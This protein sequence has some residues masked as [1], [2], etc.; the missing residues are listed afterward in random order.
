MTQGLLTLAG[1]DH[2]PGGKTRIRVGL[3]IESE[4][5]FSPCRRY[6]YRLRRRWG[7]GPLMTVIMM[8]PSVAD[9]HVDDPTVAKCRR[10]ATRLGFG[11]H[12]IGNVCAY[13]VTD[14]MRLLDVDDPVGPGNAD[15]LLR[16]AQES[17]MVVIAH[18]RLPGGLQRH[19]DSAVARLRA[20]G[21]SLYALRL[22]PDGVPMHPLARGKAHI[23]EDCRPVI[24][25][26]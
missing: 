24:W 6:R 19:A 10:I 18:G 7:D 4:A 1:E 16:M 17:D 13:R 9:I 12:V 20:A 22:T 15:A 25:P 2:D 14:K 8:N 11:C 21:I 23:P 5:E 26:G 3:D